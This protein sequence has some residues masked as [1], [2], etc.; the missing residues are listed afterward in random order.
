MSR[1][2]DTLSRKIKSIDDNNK[3]PVTP[4]SN[5]EK[6]PT[7]AVIPPKDSTPSI[8]E[9]PSQPSPEVE[10]VS[11]HS[12][13]HLSSSQSLP[14]K[15]PFK[16][17]ISEK[18]NNLQDNEKTNNSVPSPEKVKHSEEVK[19]ISS[20]SSHNKRPAPK[21]PNLIEKEKPSIK[22]TE[23]EEQDRTSKI[24]DN[25]TEIKSS[26]DDDF[27]VSKS[28]S[29]ESLEQEIILEDED[30]EEREQ[31]EDKPSSHHETS[32]KLSSSPSYKLEDG[33]VCSS[34]D[35]NS[36]SKSIGE[37][38]ISSDHST[39]IENVHNDES[40]ADTSHVSI[41]S[42]DNG[43]DISIKTAE[44]L[45]D[46]ID[47][48]HSFNETPDLNG[49]SAGISHD[50]SRNASSNGSRA[51]EQFVGVSTSDVI[52]I[53]NDYSHII[54]SSL[55]ASQDR[56]SDLIS[57][58]RRDVKSDSD[59]DH[60]SVKTVS[61]DSSN[62]GKRVKV[63]LNL[64]PEETEQ[65]TDSSESE[66][67]RNRH[68]IPHSALHDQNSVQTNGRDCTDRDSQSFKSP[69]HHRIFKKESSDTGSCASF[70]SL[71]SERES[72]DDSS[73]PPS[74]APVQILKKRTEKVG[75]FFICCFMFTSVRRYRSRPSPSICLACTDTNS[76]L[77]SIFC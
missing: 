27:K 46:L 56:V 7:S 43:K 70:A 41:V 51:G 26:C 74:D 10:G 67:N 20:R 65:G 14:I 8:S 25:G 28:E 1:G 3:V 31:F 11:E 19:E 5:N 53:S 59:F 68:G 45:E 22:E 34:C 76:I 55:T 4:T 61:S 66:I 71:A 44:K 30:Y 62:S 29:T 57:L 54:E 18:S 75:I 50:Q 52:K 48:M 58:N 33:S 37:V 38:T 39:I 9:V 64:V 72:K 36:A 2:D 13:Q 47:L 15:T 63:N 60:I 49:I 35:V 40:I 17:F 23:N 16:D 73:I 21:P 32:G 24:L 12:S 6:T 42:I 69:S 77:C